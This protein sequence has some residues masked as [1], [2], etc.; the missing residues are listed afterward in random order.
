MKKT[1]LIALLALIS[2]KKKD[3]PCNCGLIVSDDPKDYSVV[4]RNECSNNEKK[5]YLS[6]GDWMN[7]HPGDNYCITNSGKW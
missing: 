5:F 7:A 3:K 4:I 1:I 6:Q 2:C